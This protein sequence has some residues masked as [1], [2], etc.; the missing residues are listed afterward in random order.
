M[1]ILFLR[2]TYK[3]ISMKKIWM[4]VIFSFLTIVVVAQRVSNQYS[5]R[6]SQVK[7]E[8]KSKTSNEQSEKVIIWND[9][10][11]NPA[12]WTIANIGTNDEEWHFSNDPSL[13]ET[14]TALPAALVPF[15]SETAANGFL[16]VNSDGKTL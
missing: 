8:H 2:R 6:V 7:T 3:T 9:E 14:V 16:L 11:T 12:N 15:V 1:D 4:M 10:F 13:G 5:P